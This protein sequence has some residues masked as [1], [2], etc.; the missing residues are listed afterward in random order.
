MIEALSTGRHSPPGT[1][2]SP[3]NHP[4]L[5]LL[6][7]QDNISR[8]MPSEK[9]LPWKSWTSYNDAFIGYT[10]QRHT[11]FCQ[12]STDLKKF[13]GRFLGKFVV[14]RIL[15]IPPHLAYV[16][17]LPSETLLSAKQAIN[18][19]LQGSVAT[20]LTCGGVVNNQIQK[21]LFLS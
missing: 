1:C 8:P 12:I 4:S 16:A 6:T 11:W 14:K 10:R 7:P 2:M 3:Y 21:G 9:K 15:Q 20:Y 18:D 17:A 5:H 13:R 19:K